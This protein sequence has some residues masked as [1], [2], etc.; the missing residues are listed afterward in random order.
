MDERSISQALFKKISALRVTL[1]DEEQELLDQIV[2]GDY[3][4]NAHR[5]MK[6][7]ERVMTSDERAMRRTISLDSRRIAMDDEVMAHD[8]AS[9]DSRLMN[10]RVKYDSEKKAYLV[11]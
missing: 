6:G 9:T 8:A 11:E 10:F 7:A 2:S 1:T 5:A 4:V 3:E